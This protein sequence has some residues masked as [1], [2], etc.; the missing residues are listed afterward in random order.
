MDNNVGYQYAATVLHR[1]IVFVFTA[2]ADPKS[3]AIYYNV[4]DLE[5]ASSDDALDWSGFN[6]LDF[7]KEL[8]TVGMG[9]VTVPMSEDT[10]GG[11]AHGQF[12]VL[13]DQKYVYVFR[14]SNRIIFRYE[15]EPGKKIYEGT[16]RGEPVEIYDD[17]VIA[18]GQNGEELFR[19]T[20][21]EPIHVR[22][23]VHA[24]SI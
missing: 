22:P 8:R 4:L 7:P 11:V 17:T 5:V 23:A 19:T 24:N 9:M 21:E 13:S 10:T 16:L 3:D 6:K 14:R 2:D 1:G 20:V 12:K 18:F 15:I